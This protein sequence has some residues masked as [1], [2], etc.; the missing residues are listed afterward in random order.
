MSIRGFRMEIEYEHVKVSW[1][2]IYGNFI[3]SVIIMSILLVLFECTLL[4]AA[5]QTIMATINN[6]NLTMILI[7]A[8]MS[9]LPLLPLLVMCFLLFYR[10][11]L[12]ID[13][14]GIERTREI[15]FLKW[16]KFVPLENVNRF[17]CS[18]FHGRNNAN[19]YYYSIIT[20]SKG[21]NLKFGL[22]SS[23]KNMLMLIDELNSQLEKF[24]NEQGTR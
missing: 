11:S 4:N 20:T 23:E 1:K 15:L 18:H 8:I 7:C 14:N 24:R 17:N 9:I 10:E 6:P 19:V 2:Y 3:I 22:S 12:K 16:E 21:E 5:F 13:K